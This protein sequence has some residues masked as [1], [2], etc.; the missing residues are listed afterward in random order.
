MYQYRYCTVYRP[1]VLY[2][3]HLFSFINTIAIVLPDLC[4]SPSIHCTMRFCPNPSCRRNIRQTRKPFANGRSFSNHVQ[5]SSEC[6]AFVFDQNTTIA[7]EQM[8]VLAKPRSSINSTSQ[9]FKKQRLRLNP[10]SMDC[11]VFTNVKSLGN[12]D[13]VYQMLTTMPL[14]CL[15]KMTNPFLLM[16]P[17]LLIL[18]MIHHLMARQKYPLLRMIMHVSPQ[19]RN[20]LRR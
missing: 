1:L 14:L 17:L 16:Y 9:L 4:I 13:Q 8:H 20:V 6:K 11:N 18:V 19:A 10:T 5:Q 2:S 15:K 7:T 12:H 3:I